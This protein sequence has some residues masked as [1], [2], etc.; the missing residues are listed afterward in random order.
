MITVLNILTLLI[1]SAGLFYLF[2]L[3]RVNTWNS[4]RLLLAE[5]I[6]WVILT[7]VVME[8][9]WNLT[10]QEVFLLET[11]YLM[12]LVLAY[13]FFLIA[14]HNEELDRVTNEAIGRYNLLKELADLPTFSLS[15]QGVVLDANRAFLNTLGLEA[16]EIVGIRLLEWLHHNDISTAE[17][18]IQHVLNTGITVEFGARI[19]FHDGSFRRARIR[20]APVYHR[21]EVVEVLGTSRDLTQEHRAVNQATFLATV[22]T[23]SNQPIFTISEDGLILVWNRGMESLTGISRSSAIDRAY[24]DLLMDVPDLI[25]ECAASG[26]TFSTELLLRNSGISVPVLLTAYAVDIPGQP[27]AYAI[28]VQDLTRQRKLEEQLLHHQR[29]EALG[30]LAGGVAHDFNNVLTIISGNAAILKKHAKMDSKFV[31]HLD[32]II[33]STR[34]GATLTEQ[35]LTFSRRHPFTPRRMDVE[36]LIAD[37]VDLISHAGW[38]GIHFEV[39]VEPN[40]PPVMVDPGRM[41]QVL[42]NLCVN[43]R[44]AMPKG[45]TI[46]ITAKRKSFMSERDLPRGESAQPGIY[47]SIGVRDTGVGMDR[48]TIAR[49]FEPF[50]TTKG[51]SKGTGLGLSNAHGTVQQHRG[52][53]EVESELNVGSTFHIL[54]PSAERFEEDSRLMTDRRD[55]ERNQ[56]PDEEEILSSATAEEPLTQSLY[57]NETVLLVDDEALVREVGK[58]ALELYGYTVLTASDGR[59]ALDLYKGHRDEIAV[60]VLDWAM[61]NVGGKEVLRTLREAGERVPVLVQSGVWHSQQ[62]DELLRQGADGLLTKP[63]L[64]EKLI[65]EIRSLLQADS[66]DPKPET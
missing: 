25:L 41:Q 49:I 52:W 39:S 9:R 62:V 51:P 6:V 13:L 8:C 24:T 64:P 45:G 10:R 66:K 59:E 26:G 57:G 1:L 63:Y 20:L 12:M 15:T 27:T 60:V 37:T 61:R 56:M 65:E 47:V 28:Y 54:L 42:L 17:N 48:A 53:M 55:R 21:G 23:E 7:W 33:R 46:H 43:A 32:G 2:F 35:L 50:F 34:R 44:D 14:L 38:Q 18:R 22:I 11:G 19:K 40:V 30:K 16:D 4:P 36:N 5:M 29:M 3:G 58:T 31:A